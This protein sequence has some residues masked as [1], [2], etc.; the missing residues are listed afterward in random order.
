MKPRLQVSK[1]ALRLIKSFEGY[2][3]SSA[4]LADGRWTIGYG[5]TLTAREGVDVNESDAEAL[6]LYDLLAIGGAVNDLTYTPLTQNQFDALCAFAFNIGLR[7]FRGSHVL[8]LVNEG[9]MLQAAQAIEAWR[10]ADFEGDEIVVDGLIRRR[11][12]EKTLFLTPPAGFVPTPSAIIQPRLDLDAAFAQ[13]VALEAS[14]TGAQAV[15]TRVLPA[16]TNEAEVATPPVIEAAPPP[17]P[18]T[19]PAALPAQAV[20]PEVLYEIPGY[21][22]AESHEPATGRW[23]RLTVAHLALI[24]VGGLGLLAVAAGLSWRATGAVGAVRTGEYGLA[25]VAGIAGAAGV[26]SSIYQVLNRFDRDA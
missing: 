22:A 10:K 16:P 23:A 3:R 11:S 21:G 24:G 4:R 6:L 17:P 12:A 19:P 7:E 5:H 9:A 18:A 20:L 25:A 2:R 8:T 1:A 13:P 14:M 15:A 26:F